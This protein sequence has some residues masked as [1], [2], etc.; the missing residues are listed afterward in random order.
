[1]ALALTGCGSLITPPARGAVALPA[2]FSDHA[3]LQSGRPV[4]IWGR[5]EPGEEV[6]VAIAG[7]TR[8][9]TA[10][11]TGAW[12]VRLDPLE[13]GGALT[14]TV[15]SKDGTITVRDILAGEVWLG[16]G[17]SN[18]AMTVNR[19]RDFD[20]EAAQADWPQ[21]RLF[22]EESPTAETPQREPRGQW[23]ICSP[24]TVGTFSAT[25]YFFGRELHRTLGV[26]VGLVVSAVGGT[27]I[28]A[29]INADA[30]RA[31]PGLKGFFAAMA[32]DDQDFDEVA[33]R[34]RYARDLDQW[35]EAAARAKAAQKPVPKKPAD[36]VAV[37]QR[38]RGVGGLFNG[39][40]APL[41]PYTIRGVLW[42]QG[43]ANSIPPKAPYYE[44][45]LKL[46]VRD[47]RL[48]WG[49][50]EL[51]FAWVQLPSFNAPGRDW[52]GVREAMG[53][54]LE[55]PHTGMAVTIDIGDPRNIHPTN[56]QDVGKRL[57]AWALATVYGRS[58]A[59]SGPLAVARKVAGRE[60]I[61]SFQH[62]DG[63]L[64]ARDGALRGFEIRG[65]DGRWVKADARIAGATV[66]VSH[67]DV[68]VPIAVRYAW[69]DVTDANL[70]NGANLPAA[71]FRFEE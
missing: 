20:R 37:R 40:I 33:A 35:K 46:L 67:P 4:T 59:A 11:G 50:P 57:A 56:K 48:R 3:V 14:M 23:V 58:V 68:A 47:W 41:I 31:E 54:A 6:R 62:D 29:W 13:P 27:P 44:Q 19:A 2:L 24:A 21:I 25:A 39:K 60:V 66:V 34:A 28:E 42:Y 17:Q 10:D 18:M 65:S 32:K 7:Q 36:P 71:P 1:M 38:K 16:S 8:D 52:V 30:Q 45:Q 55:L 22:R 69:A 49:E 9:A 51:P 15:A 61:V 5:A 53:K 64:I 70:Y 43:E 26:P 12:R 63:G